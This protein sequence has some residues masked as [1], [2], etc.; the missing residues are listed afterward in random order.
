MFKNAPGAMGHN[1]KLI[2]SLSIHV[3]DFETI[4]FPD[5]LL[6]RCGHFPESVHD[7]SRDGLEFASL[8]PGNSATWSSPFK[9]SMETLPSTNQEPSERCTMLC[10]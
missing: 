2:D 7:E 8:S 1:Q 6:T 4:L 3:Y 9:S 10:S 5:E